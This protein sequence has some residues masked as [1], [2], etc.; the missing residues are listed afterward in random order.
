M[1]LSH[2]RVERHIQVWEERLAAGPYAHRA[3][4]PARLFHHTPIENAAC[5]LRDAVLLSREDSES[6]RCLDV[7]GQALIS[8]RERAHQFARLYFRPRT[9]TQYSIE[10]VR[11]PDERYDATAHSPTLVMLIFDASG[12]LTTNGVRFSNGNMQSYSASDDDTEEFFDSIPF[13]KVYHEGPTGGDRSII[14]ARCAEVLAP[15]PLLLEGSLTSVYCRSPA[16]RA[17]LLHDLGGN[18]RVWRSRIFVSDDSRVFEKRYAFVEEVSIKS[19]GIYFRISPRERPRD[20]NVQ[21]DVWNW[22]GQHLNRSGPRDIPAVPPSKGQWTIPRKLEDG[23][24]RVRIL[25]EGCRAYEALLP[26]GELPF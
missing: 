8:H 13:E 26:L 11:K 1:G 4:W 12:V 15:S 9:P 20:V 16:E 19:D 17:T 6:R 24:Y 23:I 21:V 14:H 18:A 25:L 22:E 3:K 7:A 5:V 2:A 10:G